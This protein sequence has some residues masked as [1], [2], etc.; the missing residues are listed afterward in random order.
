MHDEHWH[1][2]LTQARDTVTIIVDEFI[3]T[4]HNQGGYS[5]HSVSEEELRDTAEDILSMF[6][7][8]LLGRVDEQHFRSHAEALGQRRASQGIA[9]TALIDAIQL[10][11]VVLWT[12]L[13]ELAGAEA[14]PALVDNVEKLHR[15]VSHYSFWVRD[16]YVRRTAESA[17]N[18][19]LANLRFVDRLLSASR[20]GPLGLTEIADALGLDVNGHFHCLCVHPNDAHHARTVLEPLSSKGATFEHNYHGMY[21]VF[22]ATHTSVDTATVRSV[23]GL[24][25]RDVPGLAGV[26]TAAH[27]APSI[28]KSTGAPTQLA[29]A[30][31][32]RWAVAGDAL[33]SLDNGE[34]TTYTAALAGLRDKKD[35]SIDTLWAYL[36][37]GSLK[38]ASEISFCHRNTVINRL[39]LIKNLTGLDPTV[40]VDATLLLLALQRRSTDTP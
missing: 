5:A 29:D 26:R 18:L 30:S 33:S 24:I 4:F 10:D 28:F 6:I 22:W 20:I 34:M 2:L 7:D 36:R 3:A 8:A 32:L 13:R 37:T 25:F 31:E 39:K 14:M 19:R 27:S 40:P 21:V 9:L 12:R 23:P 35:P 1:S 38:E 16:S 11:F 17:H 15:L